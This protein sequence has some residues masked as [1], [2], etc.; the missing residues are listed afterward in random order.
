M[1]NWF[2]NF[3][4]SNKS[5]KNSSEIK[6]FKFFFKSPCYWSYETQPVA[7]GVAAGL[8]GAV[9][10]GL[11][12]IYAAI[13][14]VLLRG[15][16]PIA[17]LSTLVTNPLTVLPIAYFVYYV[18]T[19]V[20]GNSNSHFVIH[21]FEWDFSSFHAFWANL[22]AWVLQ[23]GKVFLVGLPIVSVCLGLLGYFGTIFVLKI[24]TVLLGKK[25]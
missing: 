14:V 1:K 17:L 4:S 16:L 10:P 8:A 9:I 18:G 19:L 12:F 2:E 21:S 25:S 13:L 6:G 11:Q 24:S 23:F 7:R 20:I 15:N 22:S 3:L 5:I